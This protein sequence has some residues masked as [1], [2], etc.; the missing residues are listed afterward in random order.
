MSSRTIVTGETV[1]DEGPHVLA[2]INNRHIPRPVNTVVGD[3]LNNI[4]VS[5]QEQETARRRG[6]ARAI[7][8]GK[9]SNQYEADA[10]KTGR[11]RKA[12]LLR[13]ALEE[14]RPWPVGLNPD[15]GGPGA[16]QVLGVIEV[17]N[18]NTAGIKSVSRKSVGNECHPVRVHVPLGGTVETIWTGLGRNPGPYDLIL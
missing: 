14:E 17:R 3:G 10:Q 18:Q 16:L 7:G 13:V 6:T 15:D 4:S 11:R 9:T 1:R 5:I 2:F 12:L 8:A